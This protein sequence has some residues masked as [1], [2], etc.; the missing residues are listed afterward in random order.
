MRLL[1]SARL[2]FVCL[3]IA[4]VS[5][6]CTTGE[7]RYGKARF[8]LPSSLS[9]IHSPGSFTALDR[10]RNNPQIFTV[11]RATHN[12]D[13]FK[14]SDAQWY[15]TGDAALKAMDANRSFSNA[16]EISR[17]SGYQ[18][19]FRTM[20]HVM[21]GSVANFGFVS[22]DV[23]IASRL[24]HSR[25]EAYFFALAQSGRAHAADPARFSRL[26]N[27]VHFQ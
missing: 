9:R 27:T 8:T 17:S 1:A 14:L 10:S 4:C 11:I 20:D 6:S 2:R 25:D 23:V 13:P 18:S 19:G 5:V 7:M 21:A 16:R 15:R 12:E 3:L 26:M 24:F 22:S